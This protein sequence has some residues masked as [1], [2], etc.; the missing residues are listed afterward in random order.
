[1]TDI[2]AKLA[3]KISARYA[4]ICGDENE[5]AS[6][7]LQPKPKSFRVNNLK[8]SVQHVIQRMKSYGFAIEPVS[9]HD[10]AFT[11]T[12][13]I[14]KTLEHFL[15]HI[16]LQELS[17]MIPILVLQPSDS[18][19][20]C[21][22]APGSKTTQAADTMHNRGLIVANDISF[23]RTKILRFHLEKYGIMNTYV[24]EYDIRRFPSSSLRF[25]K[26]LLDAPCSSESSVYKSTIWSEKR[27]FGFAKLQKQMILKAF[28]ML[29]P[30]GTLV[31][32]TCT[33]APEENESVVQ[34]LLNNRECNLE[35]IQI[36]ELELSQGI[37]SWKK[38]RYSELQK[39]AR[40]WPHIHGMEGFFVAK[41]T[42]P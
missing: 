16:Y 38:E 36:P 27:I 34:H 15:G 12:G 29:E 30:G 14:G 42:K 41:I 3:E 22:A 17:S 40:V 28:D 18:L 24:T 19:L 7:L 13:D 4:N 26:I 21:C 35:K 6:S 31:Y 1:M 8:T 23:A 2:R 10:S 33:F 20:D 25:N 39:C 37:S 9:W 11:T 5:F 32:S